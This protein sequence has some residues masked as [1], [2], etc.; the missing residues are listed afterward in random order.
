M[1][2]GTRRRL[3]EH[4]V[5]KEK[6]L[7]ES[8]TPLEMTAGHESEPP[9]SKQSSRSTTPRLS[10]KFSRSDRRKDSGNGGTKAAFDFGKSKITS[11]NEVCCPPSSTHI[12]DGPKIGFS[13]WRILFFGRLKPYL[14]DL[15]A[16]CFWMENNILTMEKNFNLSF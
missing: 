10:L 13:L 11:K 14:V 15:L 7:K 8:E 6:E 12:L 5:Y 2:P 3:L 16:N 9:S 1:T 4:T